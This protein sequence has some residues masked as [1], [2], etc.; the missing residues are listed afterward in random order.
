MSVAIA[1][2]IGIGASIF[3]GM[4]SLSAQR[5]AIRAQQKQQELADLREKRRLLRQQQIIAGET[6]NVAA[7]I[8]GMGSSSLVAGL[9]GLTNQVQSQLG[10]QAQSSA[11]SQQATGFMQQAGRYNMYGDLFGNMF[12]NMNLGRVGFTGGAPSY[13]APT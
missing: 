13:T 6:V 1:P 9:S 2:L 5:K 3:F 4:K 10:Y 12:G 8:G 7:N 11:L